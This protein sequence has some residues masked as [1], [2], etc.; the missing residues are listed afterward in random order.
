MSSLNSSKPGGVDQ[1][2][3]TPNSVSIASMS[4][5]SKVKISDNN[6][7]NEKIQIEKTNLKNEDSF[8]DFEEDIKITK[9]SKSSKSAIQLL[10]D[11]SNNKNPE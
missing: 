4:Q 3:G 7:D 5:K 8:A 6:N 1:K 2:G 11:Q 9:K 10:V